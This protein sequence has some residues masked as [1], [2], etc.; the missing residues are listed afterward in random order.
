MLIG[1]ISLT[2]QR[3]VVIPS[4]ELSEEDKKLIP[5]S[6]VKIGNVEGHKTGGYTRTILN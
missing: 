1:N 6:K 3:K 2:S 5:V 4:F